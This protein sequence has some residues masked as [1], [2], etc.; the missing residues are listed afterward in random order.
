MTDERLLHAIE[1]PTDLRKLPRDQVERVAREIREEILERVSQTGGHLASS[2]GAV[3]LITAI[4]Y[5]FDTPQ[6][7][8]IL[9]VGHQG[10]PHKMLTGRRED[11]ESIGQRDGMSK[12]LVV[13]IA[14]CCSSVRTSSSSGPS[15]QSFDSSKPSASSAA[16]NTARAAGD[17]S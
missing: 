6:D 12:D 15:K 4:H 7:R 17:A 3:E 5:V 16:S 2:L 1:R 8:L 9:D 11:F 10:Y 13:R 14:G